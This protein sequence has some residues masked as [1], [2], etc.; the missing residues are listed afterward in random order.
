MDV[1]ASA[2]RVLADVIGARRTLPQALSLEQNREQEKTPGTNGNRRQG[3]LLQEICYGVVRWMPR[4]EL[5]LAKLL[6]QPIGKLEPEVS[7]LLLIG[8]YRLEHMHAPAHRVVQLTVQGCDAIRRSWAR[9]LVNAI[10]RRYLRERE[11][12]KPQLQQVASAR[13][14]HP[15]WLIDA[16]R[17]AWPQHWE[18]ILLADNQHPPMHLRVNR[19]RNS[20]EQYQEL[21]RQA[22]IE[23]AAI[24]CCPQGLVLKQALPVTQLPGFRQGRVSV[25]DGGAQLCPALLDLVP[26]LRVLDACA[27]PGGKSAHILE[28]GPALE[29]MVCADVSAFR[30]ER[31]K[32][33]LRRLQLQAEI[34]QADLR[35][36]YQREQACFDRI[37]LDTPC[38]ATGIIRRHP[39][40]KLSKGPA[41]IKALLQLQRELLDAAW[42]LLAPGGRLLYASCT[43]LPEE[44]EGQIES[45]LRRQPQA[46]TVPLQLQW[47]RSTGY[48]W[49]ILP[50]ESDLDGFYYAVLRRH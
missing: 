44:N 37:L 49:Q 29:R 21:L 42:A 50:G 3:A 31:L 10:L 25:Q 47:G 45:F 38:S 41:D 35:L 7:C 28:S 12:L 39:D 33:S 30:I 36:L 20:R 26:G 23:A 5:I 1:A 16:F 2:T 43:I 8:L 14:A 48:G 15:G 40:V 32:E 11:Q 9:G 24:P 22:G 18:Q 34:I 46:A 4:L 17:A 6:H 27:A 19:R 13:Y